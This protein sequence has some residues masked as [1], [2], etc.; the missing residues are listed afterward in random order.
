MAQLIFGTRQQIQFES[1]NDFFE[2]LGFLAKNDRTTSIHW[3]RNEIQ[4][5]W[6]SEGRIHCYKNIENFPVYFSNAFSAGTNN[7]IH[8][9]NCNEYI[10]YIIEEHS[11]QIGHTQDLSA[12]RLT[13]PTQYATDFNRGLQL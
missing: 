1:D 8:R 6:G 2:A 7:I 5:A 12:I 4:G 11:F 3:E 13:I 9:I 10:K